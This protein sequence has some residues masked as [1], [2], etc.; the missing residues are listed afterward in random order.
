V[1]I[2]DRWFS[3]IIS[4]GKKI[5]VEWK[6]PDLELRKSARWG[7]SYSFSLN[8]LSYFNTNNFDK[9]EALILLPPTEYFKKNGINLSAPEPSKFYYFTGLKVIWANNPNAENANYIVAVE[10]GQ[11]VFD[12]VVNKNQLDAYLSEFRKY[13][14]SL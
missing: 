8:I 2:Y 1:K 13:K 4:D 11:L 14:I 3:A 6:Y 7:D 9:K 10:N 5:S 12:P